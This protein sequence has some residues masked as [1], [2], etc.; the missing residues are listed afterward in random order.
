MLSPLIC[1]LPSHSVHSLEWLLG[2]RFVSL[3]IRYSAFLQKNEV[4][5]QMLIQSDRFAEVREEFREAEEMQGALPVNH[6]ILLEVH[7]LLPPYRQHHDIIICSYS[8]NFPQTMPLMEHLTKDVIGPD[9]RKILS[10][11]WMSL[12]GMLTSDVHGLVGTLFLF[13]SLPLLSLFILG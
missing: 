3:L 7:I 1:P 11:D 10:D 5:G 2:A 6:P 12:R 4:L 8:F 13:S 9:A